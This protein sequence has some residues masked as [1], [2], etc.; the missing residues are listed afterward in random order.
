MSGQQPQPETVT[1]ATAS[2][3]QPGE[4]GAGQNSG[5]SIDPR[6][7]RRVNL[8]LLGIL[9]LFVA[10]AALLRSPRE[11]AL[12]H[13]A[14]GQEQYAQG[15]TA[16]AIELVEKAIGT[17][18]DDARLYHQLAVMLY[19]QEKYE[20]CL[21]N[22]TIAI[23]KQPYEPDWYLARGAVFRDQ[24][25]YREAVR[26]ADAVVEL[27][28]RGAR[29]SYSDALNDAAYCRALSGED[30]DRGFRDAEL[31]VTRIRA[32]QR[33]AAPTLR[34]DAL[35]RR[36]RQALNRSLARTLDTRGYL[37][38]KL[39]EAARSR[40]D[41]G[42]AREHLLAARADFDE[43]LDLQVRN[44]DEVEK[45]LLTSD[46]LTRRYWGAVFAADVE[47]LGEMHYNRGLTLAGLGEDRRAQR[48]FDLARDCGF[49]VDEG[50]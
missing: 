23:D 7:V 1:S 34:E 49:P 40:D 11:V 22:L 35:A 50:H 24:K 16:E 43:A 25:R 26:D 13:L 3:T 14:A 38:Y 45:Q 44:L 48:A 2:S 27:A 41:D 6:R 4:Q 18:P 28:E 8:S 46:P 42:A 30:L 36:R 37:H 31:A 29:V 33:S 12:W 5:A 39:A 9:V 47:G 19:K 21:K 15:N 17:S 10:T 32:A 20:P